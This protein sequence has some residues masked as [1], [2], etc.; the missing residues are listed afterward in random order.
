MMDDDEN[1]S[2]KI[3]I[4]DLYTRKNEIEE[5]KLKV[6]RKILHRVHTKIKITSRQRKSEQFTFFV[7][8]EF[9]VGTPRY[10]V[11]ACTA[12]I[13]D[14]LKDN[15][16]LVKY[17]HPNLLFISWAHYYDKTKRMN[18][19]KEY[20][21]NIDGFGNLVSSKKKS[22]NKGDD[23]Q[24]LNTLMFANKK[25]SNI[26]IDNK[27]KKDYKQTTSYK[28]TG[29]FIYSSGLLKSLQDSTT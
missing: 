25:S 7:V 28:P 22:Q 21:V 9:L 5:N 8:P 4:D 1:F 29:N 18:I 10:D 6:F 24:N 27:P 23:E 3:S 12:Y 19:K 15:G 11:A 16:F 13:I 17:T 26:K 20:G 14:K 2:E